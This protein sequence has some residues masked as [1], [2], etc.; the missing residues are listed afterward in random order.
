MY[1]KVNVI[2]V[3]FRLFVFM[4]FQ[5][6][7]Y[8]SLCV[9]AQL[10]QSCPTFCDP[11][12]CSLSGSSVHGILQ[13]RILEGVAMPFSKASSQSRGRTHSSECPALQ[14]DSAVQFQVLCSK[15]LLLIYFMYS[16]VYL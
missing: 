14:A 6:I 15:S 7:E 13:A 5:D 3:F 10:L 11:M 9:S 2:H 8:C 16:C 1:S 4:L 12:D